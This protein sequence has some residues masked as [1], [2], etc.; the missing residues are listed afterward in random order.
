MKT[1]V[2]F[3]AAI[4][5]GIYAACGVGILISLGVI[6]SALRE[7]RVAR[8]TMEKE[9]A[10]ARA[11]RAGQAIGLLFIAMGLVAFVQSTVAPAL[12][13]LPGEEL[14]GTMASPPTP[15]STP[16][17]VTPTPTLERPT[18]PAIIV[19]PA[20]TPVSA[21]P[22]SLPSAC[23]NPQARITSPGAGAT[24]RGKVE[25]RGTANI[26]RLSFYRLEYAPGTSPS[27][28]RFI[29][30]VRQPVED[31]LLLVWDTAGLEPG[32]YSLR[33]TV[34]DKTG[35]YP[36]PCVVSVTLE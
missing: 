21:T 26:E 23:P 30:I 32:P 27:E 2:D 9:R 10:F 33:L 36:E 24:V 17:P 3:I 19:V 5:P 20:E 13:R 15:A 12:A 16:Q 14:P 29:E 18:R 6:L 25:V 1:L 31:G 7:R 22:T 34:V 35:N 8:L 4:A 28:W 11:C